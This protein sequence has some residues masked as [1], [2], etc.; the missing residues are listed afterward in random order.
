[1][2]DSSSSFLQDNMRS[3]NYKLCSV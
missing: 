2:K 1:M 3:S